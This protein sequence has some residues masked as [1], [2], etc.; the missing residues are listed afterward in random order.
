M[1]T[2]TITDQAWLV[3]YLTF[4]VQMNSPSASRRSTG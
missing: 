2:P 1:N 3:R 4:P